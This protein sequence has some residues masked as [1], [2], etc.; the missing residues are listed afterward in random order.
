L[1]DPATRLS[2]CGDACS[3]PCR[4]PILRDAALAFRTMSTVRADGML[5][6]RASD[7]ASWDEGPVAAGR[8]QRHTQLPNH[9]PGCQDQSCKV[10]AFARN[11]TCSRTMRMTYHQLWLSERE[12]GRRRG[13]AQERR[14]RDRLQAAPRGSVTRAS[15]LSPS[16]SDRRMAWP[17][18]R[19]CSMPGSSSTGQ[20][21][22]PR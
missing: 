2:E 16:G 20:G 4:P 10:L 5:S 9:S 17:L 3:G 21:R 6:T 11:A 13:L 1:K 12:Y 15:S 18:V 22:W 7:L 8:L 14:A 19:A